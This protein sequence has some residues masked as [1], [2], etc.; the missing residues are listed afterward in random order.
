MFYSGQMA[1]VQVDACSTDGPIE[2]I[3]N[4]IDNVRMKNSFHSIFGYLPALGGEIELC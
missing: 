2:I 1:V 3:Y 4:L